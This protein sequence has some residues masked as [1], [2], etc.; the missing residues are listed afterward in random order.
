[1]RSATTTATHRSARTA[2]SP[3]TAA[4]NSLSAFHCQRA[5]DHRDRLPVLSTR[6]ETG[7]MNPADANAASCIDLHGAAMP[8]QAG[9][10]VDVTERAL[11]VCVET[12]EAAEDYAVEELRSLA[13]TAGAEVA[14]ELHQRRM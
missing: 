9:H 8:R 12:D 11:I 14:G 1:A 10:I 5:A 4:C 2:R 7:I 3:A 6:V 13:M